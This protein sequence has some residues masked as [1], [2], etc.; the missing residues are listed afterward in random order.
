MTQRVA[1]F[2]DYQ[3]VYKGARRAFAHQGSPHMFGQVHPARLALKLKGINSDGRKLSAIRVYRGMPSSRH[4]PKGF[5]ACQRQIAEWQNRWNVA[6]IT[7]PLNYRVPT[8]PKE[9]GID[10]RIAIDLVMMAMRDEY[11]VGILFSADTDLV[12]ALEAVVGIKGS[13]SVEVAVWKPEGQSA[14]RLRVQ[15]HNIW[16]HL[17]GPKDYQH[18]QDLIDYTRKGAR[19][20]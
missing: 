10:V 20:T 19:L 5:G 13:G 6:A 11:D 16:C 14:N 2:L 1:V 8:D 12:P 9:K 15:A 3:N 17:L 4:D 7:R 18:V